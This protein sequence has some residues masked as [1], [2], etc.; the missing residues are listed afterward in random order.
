MVQKAC[1]PAQFSPRPSHSD[2]D[3][4]H[5]HNQIRV[6][7]VEDYEPLR[8]FVR[9]TLAQRPDFR[10]IGEASDGLEA[11]RKAEELQPDLI[12]LDI[13]LPTLNGIEAARRMRA[14]GLR[15]RI[16]FLTQD[17]SR[18]IAEEALGTGAQGYVVKSFGA[19]DLLIAVEAV[20][21][22]KQFLKSG[23]QSLRASITYTINVD[24]NLIRARCVGLITFDDVINHF[25]ELPNCPHRLDVFLDLSETTSL[26]DS[27]QLSAVSRE[28]VKIR[29]RVRFG[30]CAIVAGRDALFWHDA[31]I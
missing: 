26:P 6:L 12:L 7:V 23:L 9:S 19:G 4:N 31:S 21:Q 3:G 5:L 17:C 22:G 14:A 1:T 20:V 18:D 27:S 15:S 29:E 28:I 16:L 2:G 25:G 30:I 13:G 11:V 10:V 24:K 8:R